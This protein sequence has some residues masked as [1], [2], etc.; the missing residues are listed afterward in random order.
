MS[1]TKNLK[2]TTEYPCGQTIVEVRT[3]TDTEMQN[4]GWERMHYSDINPTCFVLSDG[5]ILYPSSDEEGNSPGMFFGLIGGD[6]I[7]ITLMEKSY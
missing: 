2:T 5:S 7:S 1:K 6:S 4:E 3:M